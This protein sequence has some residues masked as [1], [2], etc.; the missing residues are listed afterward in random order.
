MSGV[1]DALLAKSVIFCQM[2]LSI[3]IVTHARESNTTIHR[4]RELSDRGDENSHVGTQSGSGV[5][6]HDGSW[7][8]LWDSGLR[9]LALQVPTLSRHYAAQKGN[10]A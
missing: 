6:D 3:M 4:H 8:M 2:E 1:S 9:A 5:V 10:R 7:R